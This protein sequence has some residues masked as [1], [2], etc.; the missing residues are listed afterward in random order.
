[1][2]E[3]SLSEIARTLDA[4]ERRI[5][6]KVSRELY[7]RDRAEWKDDVAAIRA[8][9]ERARADADKIAVALTARL[10]KDQEDRRGMQRLVVGAFVS[11]IL[12][13][14]GSLAVFILGRI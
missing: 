5:S 12:S 14:A 10:E 8:E 13:F 1:M 11:A 4:Q 7:D 3:M 9:I 6:S 2:T